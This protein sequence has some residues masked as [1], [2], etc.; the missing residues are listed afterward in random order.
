MFT[1]AQ[2]DEPR[3]GGPQKHHS[4]SIADTFLVPGGHVVTIRRRGGSHT[5]RHQR[6][7]AMPAGGS[8]LRPAVFGAFPRV[9]KNCVRRT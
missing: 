2:P 6:Q 8:K 9:L 7:R 5:K 4:G 3:S 1:R